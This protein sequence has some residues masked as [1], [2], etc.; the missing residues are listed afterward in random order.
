MKPTDSDGDDR[1]AGVPAE[2]GT[3]SP[4]VSSPV[5]TGGGGTTFEQHVGAYWLAQLLVGAI[6]P[7]LIDTTVSEVMFQTERL[8]W[9]T[10]DLLIVC[11]AGDTLRKLAGQVKRS[12]T[13]SASNAECVKTFV[14]F[15]KDFNGSHFAK[16]NDRLALITLRGTNTLLE[17]FVGLLDCARAARDGA[18]FERR[19]GTRGLLHNTAKHYCD[20]LQKIIG[21]A[22]G[23]PVTAAYIWPFIR[24]LHVLSLDLYSATR[25]AEAH[26]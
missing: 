3:A 26:V 16:D 11:T 24:V 14:D 7:V 4:R 22:E 13:V 2:T 20:E 9:H 8:G 12:F 10:D 23:K 18:E 15:W 1:D 19:L 17:H 5:A 25:Q 21:D 6:P